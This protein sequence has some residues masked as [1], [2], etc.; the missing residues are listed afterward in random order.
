LEDPAGGN[1]ELILFVATTSDLDDDLVA[2]IRSALRTDLSPR[3]VP[4]HVVAVHAVPRNLT[5]KKLELP[6]KRIL[7]GVPAAQVVSR[8]ALADP[9]SL[10]DFV[11]LAAERSRLEAAR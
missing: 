6:I 9:T 7:Q 5:G 4:D 2:A 8:D 11:A 3:H 10:D 1:G